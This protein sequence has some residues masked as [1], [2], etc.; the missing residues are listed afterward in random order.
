MTQGLRKQTRL[1][2]P[3]KQLLVGEVRGGMGIFATW[4]APIAAS[5]TTA[6]ATAIAFL[7]GLEKIAAQ[8]APTTEVTCK[9]TD[10]CV[11]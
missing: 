7:A 2:A 11:L 5:A 8:D 4:T 1:T 10:S 9:R 3:T 6:R